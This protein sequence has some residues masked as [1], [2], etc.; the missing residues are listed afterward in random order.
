MK[1]KYEQLISLLEEMFQ[2]DNE[3]LDFGI[4][5]IMNQKRG[6]IRKFLH[7]DLLPQVKQAFAK[8]QSIDQVH[9]R[10]EMEQVK[11]NLED[12]GVDPESSPKYRVLQE[13]LTQSV[14]LN[15]LENEVYSHLVTFFSRYYDRGDFIS[16]RKYK[17]DV[18]AIPY[19]GEEVKLHWANSDQYYVKTSEYFRDYSFKLPSGKKV[20]FVLTEAFT[21]QNNNKEQEGKERRFILSEE[22]PMYEEN[23][24]LFIR[25]EYREDKEKQVTLNEQT[26]KHIFAMEEFSDW[27][28]EFR[29]LAP[30]EKNKNRT[31]FEKHLN[32]YTSRN[33]F[34]YFIHKDLGG[35]LRREL[36]FYIKSEIMHLDDLDTE[37][38]ARIEQYLSKIRVIKTIAHKIIKFLEQIEN[39]QKKLWL[40]KKFVVETNYCITLD[41]VPEELYSE[42]IKNEEQIK[43]WKH[44]YSLDEIKGDLTNPGFSEPLTVEFLKSNPYLVH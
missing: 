16:K 41:R 9:I 28:E 29:I 6:E 10:K 12:A 32:D 36:D 7:E 27:L 34:D 23:G 22:S 39:F 31:L 2:F 43:E 24:E 38:E 3:D 30:T 4:Y 40:K 14:D 25:F 33:T 20:H 17:K 8:Y 26:A 15:A 5:R 44:L 35:F 11:K 19:E 42:I 13:Q 1:T 37:N 21:E 18:Y